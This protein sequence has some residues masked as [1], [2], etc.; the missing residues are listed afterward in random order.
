MK[1]PLFQEIT[2]QNEITIPGL[3]YFPGYISQTEQDVLLSHIDAAE[4]NTDLRRRVQH[5]GYRY[6]YQARHASEADYLGPLPS[7]LHSLSCRLF[8]DV[9]FPHKPDQAIINE[10]LPGQGITAHIDCVPCFADTIASISL[11]SH[12][13]MD[14]TNTISQKKFRCRLNGAA[15]YH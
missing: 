3:D 7:W 5:Y 2:K 12:C 14:F 1:V 4:W 6:D 9:I 8:E 15:F 11:G 10:Y 13:M